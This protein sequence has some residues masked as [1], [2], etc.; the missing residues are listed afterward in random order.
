MGKK[1]KLIY[2]DQVLVLLFLVNFHVYV[3]GKIFV[4]LTSQPAKT[5]TVYYI[6][7]ASVMVEFPPRAV[8]TFAIDHGKSFL[9]VVP[10][11]LHTFVFIRL[12]RVW[13][14]FILIFAF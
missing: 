11:L 3:E 5:E 12:I 4:L 7:Y 13:F 9:L 2:R 10:V 6:C 1:F 14:I 8:K